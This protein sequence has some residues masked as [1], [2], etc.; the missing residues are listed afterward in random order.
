MLVSQERIPYITFDTKDM[1]Y[2]LN[3]QVLV[4][5]CNELTDGEKITFLAM[6]CFDYAR[7]VSGDNEG[8]KWVRNGYCDVSVGHLAEYRGVT[9]V[10]IRKQLQGLEKFG[11]IYREAKAEEPNSSTRKYFDFSPL[12]A[13]QE[14]V[15]M[16]SASMKIRKV[17]SIVDEDAT[18]I[19]EGD[20]LV[21]P[22]NKCNKNKSISINT[23]VD[24]T[25]D[26]MGDGPSTNLS[27]I[28]LMAEEKKTIELSP[29]GADQL[30]ELSADLLL[31]DVAPKEPAQS[32]S[33]L[34]GVYK[35]IQAG[36]LGKITGT[37]LIEYFADKYVRA[38]KRPFSVPVTERAST[39][40][41]VSNS[42]LAKH[43]AQKAIDII[44][45]TFELY[46]KAG[47]ATVDYP[48]PSLKTLTM[49]WMVNKI[50]DTA[51]NTTKAEELRVEREK[52]VETI[53]TPYA[54]IDT[55]TIPEGLGLVLRQHN[56]FTQFCMA[57]KSGF[58][59]TELI[60]EYKTEMDTVT[61]FKEVYLP[62]WQ[63]TVQV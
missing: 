43:G 42:L 9:P 26:R 40:R 13:R 18:L 27:N 36:E 48:R 63:E 22:N 3:P 57:A 41:I 62:L 16:K 39:S 6:L 8:T 55:R 59:P 10:A 52:P 24:T 21:S 54:P 53:R 47:L 30:E 19:S 33:K 17:L 38:Y 46:E 44:D 56:L 5:G 7:K 45:K 61:K 29:S 35:K 25:F 20:N 51:Y 37:D 4:M 32:K 23:D 11:L 2:V 31:G 14:E 28:P 12:L 1:P 58:V 60:T 15:D 50:L 34:K 49:D